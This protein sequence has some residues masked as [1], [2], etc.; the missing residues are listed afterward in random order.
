MLP[1]R[2]QASRD[3]QR[4]LTALFVLARRP[5]LTDNLPSI[6]GQYAVPKEEGAAEEWK[7]RLLAVANETPNPV[8]LAEMLKTILRR[9]AATS[10]PIVDPAVYVRFVQQEH[11]ASYPRSSYDTM[12][13]NQLDSVVI[14]LLSAVFEVVAAIALHSESNAMSAGRL[15][16]LFGWWLL[17]SVPDG[18]TDWNGLYQ[19]YKLAGQRTEHLF[20]ARLR[21]QTTQQKMPRRLVQLILSYPF[22]ES[23]ASSEHLPLPPASTFPRKVLHV[24][25]GTDSALPTGTDPAKVL[26]DALIAKLDEDASA[27]QWV[28]LRTRDG[29][30]V[31]LEAVLSE[32]SQSFLEELSHAKGLELTSPP[33]TPQDESDEEKYHP[34]SSD[35]ERITTRRRSQSWGDAPRLEL[36]RSGQRP[37]LGDVAESPTP[38]NS[39][40]RSLEKQ[41]SE[42]NL[43]PAEWNNFAV[44][45]FGETSEGVRDLSLSLKK[46]KTP[47]RHAAK[48]AKLVTPVEKKKFRISGGTPSTTFVV[49]SEEVV[50]I[51]DAF[52]HFVEDG[53]LDPVA[54]SSWPRFALVQLATSLSGPDAEVIDWLL[55][56]V[57]K[58]EVK[59]APSL[60]EPLPDLRLMES[61]PSLSTTESHASRFG[62]GFGLAAAFTKSFRRRSSFLGAYQSQTAPARGKQILGPVA[63][64]KPKHQSKDSA[65]SNVPTEYTI[66]EMGEI[67][68]IPS[69]LELQEG[70]APAKADSVL[71][72]TS[73]TDWI[74]L[75]EGGAHVVFRYRGTEPSL[76]GKVIR[77]VK[78]AA[79]GEPDIA[80]RETWKYKLLPQIV[81][82]NLLAQTTPT[83]INEQWAR[84]VV[85]PTEM[86]RPTARRAET[87][88]PLA[89]VIDYTVPAQL[90]DDLLGSTPDGK[91][92]AIEI[93][94]KWGFL[95]SAE[96]VSP[97][98][99]ASVKSKI[100]RFC[101]HQHYKGAESSYCPL[102]LYSGDRMRVRKALDGLWEQWHHSDG[103]KNNL[104]VFVDGKKILPSNVS[105][106]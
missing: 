43:C 72:R 24:A 41:R 87:K 36:S 19:A 85:T 66:G 62:S 80:L 50:E 101:L 77:L 9:L 70:A 15:C 1:R 27:P 96:N 104:R 51:D 68:M 92:L 84:G 49:A 94:P 98:E 45:G 95:P 48:Y 74:Y 60:D 83:P 21:F 91:V 105:C 30:S 71:T 35:S 61:R 57:K 56:T 65:I 32:D 63:E 89:D 12:F 76:Q 2:F 39:S 106:L 31:T 42:A 6:V 7:S 69:N 29:Q 46:P 11:A 79:V 88:G 82:P 4:H 23:S 20:Y 58:R 81:P 37:S 3:R 99:A 13:I 34:F 59:R 44:S 53:Q 16:H 55:V 64:T 8:D 75:A 67:V 103:E 97:A 25:L 47:V 40:K 54:S 28:T 100:C 26:G 17:G 38:S 33:I 93:K 22:G 78:V 102:D 73:A 90:M 10:K 14:Q 52:L 18:T 5:E 86:L